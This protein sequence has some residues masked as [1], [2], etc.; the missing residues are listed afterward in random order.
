[1]KKVKEWLIKIFREDGAIFKFLVDDK[2]K[3]DDFKYITGKDM[4]TIVKIPHSYDE[5]DNDS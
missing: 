5:S 3:D 1:M 4:A 2:D